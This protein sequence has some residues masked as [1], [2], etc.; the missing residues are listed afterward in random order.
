[1]FGTEYREITTAQKLIHSV[2][3]RML[4]RLLVEMTTLFVVA[5]LAIASIPL[6]AGKVNPLNP[7][8]LTWLPVFAIVFSIL[9][10]ALATH[11]CRPSLTDAARRID[12]TIGTSELFLTSLNTIEPG[13]ENSLFL[14]FCQDLERAALPLKPRQ[15][16]RPRL[17]PALKFMVVLLAVDVVL[18]ATPSKIATRSVM[19]VRAQQHLARTMARKLS[20]SAE[21][22]VALEQLQQ[23]KTE[24]ELERKA[25]KL[26]QSMAK[27]KAKSQNTLA[28]SLSELETALRAKNVKHSHEV[29]SKI[30]NQ[31]A[32]TPFAD[33]KDEAA[34][35]LSKL[36]E[37]TADKDLAARMQD[38]GKPGTGQGAGKN[39]EANTAKAH[40]NIVEQQ[41]F[42]EDLLISVFN[43]L[44]SSPPVR[45]ADSSQASRPDSQSE[46]YPSFP[47]SAQLSALA[48]DSFDKKTVL[49]YFD[50]RRSR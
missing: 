50:L 13:S 2:R 43:S 44:G 39:G 37:S 42:L 16:V 41:E 6:L 12:T 34:K 30:E 3:K 28:A 49:R 47:T 18:F 46:R 40:S 26:W 45:D 11:F 24:D 9:L 1:M 10:G 22:K 25:K 4:R 32:S 27:K 38:I 8:I 5:G 31:L 36:A 17:A 48:L 29:V 14:L 21:A 7:W 19:V 33:L 15:I 20:I 23:A 35:A